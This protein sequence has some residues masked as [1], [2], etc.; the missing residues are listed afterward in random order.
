MTDVTALRHP[1][2][3]C[4]SG[5]AAENMGYTTEG[6]MDT[7]IVYHNFIGLDDDSETSPQTR[8]LS[9]F[10]KDINIQENDFVVLKMDV[11]G[12]EFS[13]LERMMADDTYK[14]IDEVRTFAK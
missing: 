9:Q 2:N 10:L 5:T 3:Q 13:L 1:I 6:T 7:L 12:I 11:E 4:I 14:L 8:G